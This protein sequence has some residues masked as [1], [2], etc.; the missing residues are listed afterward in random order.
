MGVFIGILLGMIISTLLYLLG[1]CKKPIITPG[2]WYKHKD[3]DFECIVTA[4]NDNTVFYEDEF[5]YEY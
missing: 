3:K 1:W 4:V 2:L 5:N